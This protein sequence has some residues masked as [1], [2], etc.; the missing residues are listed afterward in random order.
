MNEQAK[1]AQQTEPQHPDQIRKEL[2]ITYNAFFVG[3]P[4]FAQMILL[5]EAL[6]GI[7]T[8]ETEGP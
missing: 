1:K 2:A 5:E 3:A 7:K 4:V 6:F 8:K